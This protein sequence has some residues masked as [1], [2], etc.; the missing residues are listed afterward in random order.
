MTSGLLRRSGSCAAGVYM[1]WLL[2]GSNP[3]NEKLLL[4][5]YEKV[6]LDACTCTV[7]AGGDL[8][9]KLYPLSDSVVKFH[10]YG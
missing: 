7:V 1:S 2:I 8:E 6:I 5:P 4:A 9:I 10:N 3:T